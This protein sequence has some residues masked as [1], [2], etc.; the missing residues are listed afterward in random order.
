LEFIIRVD[1]FLN[2]HFERRLGVQA[3][4]RCFHYLGNSLQLAPRGIYPIK[5]SIYALILG[6]SHT[7]GLMRSKATV[8]SFKA[9]LLRDYHR[10]LRALL[11]TR[12]CDCLSR[13]RG[14]LLRRGRRE[15]RV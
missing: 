13:G 15:V 4:N 3:C 8:P 12:S 9:I 14:T 10:E 11:G 7:A 6:G 2:R 5:I 1:G